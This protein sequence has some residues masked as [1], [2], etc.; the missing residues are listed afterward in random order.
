MKRKIYPYFLTLLKN[1]FLIKNYTKGLAIFNYTLDIFL[2]EILSSLLKN[3]DFNLLFVSNLINDNQLNL[4][5]YSQLQYKQLNL[6][7]FNLIVNLYKNLQLLL[8]NLLFNF[9]KIVKIGKICYINSIKS[10]I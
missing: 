4:Y 3:N 6:S 7:K 9:V 8:C 2:T 5:S 10:S 1:G